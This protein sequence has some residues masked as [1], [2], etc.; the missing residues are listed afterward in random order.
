MLHQKWQ[1]LFLC[2][3]HTMRHDGLATHMAHVVLASAAFVDFQGEV[4]RLQ[5]VGDLACTIGTSFCL[6]LA[7]IALANIALWILLSACLRHLASLDTTPWILLAIAFVHLVTLDNALWIPLVWI[8][9]PFLP[10]AIIC[11]PRWA[12]TAAAVIGVTVKAKRHWSSALSLFKINTT[13]NI[14][15]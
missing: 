6:S 13:N 8:L 10:L 4:I 5:S 2:V 15:K 11:K 9:C 3:W 12:T 14:N 1:T 7:N